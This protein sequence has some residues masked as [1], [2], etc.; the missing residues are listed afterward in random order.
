M[1]R[2]LTAELVWEIRME[3]KGWSHNPSTTCFLLQL[4][5]LARLK[6]DE[7]HHRRITVTR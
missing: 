2:A 5:P 4:P 7:R 1:M 6:K 3:D